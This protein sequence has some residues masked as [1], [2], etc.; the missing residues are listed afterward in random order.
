MGA[1]GPF[2]R[3]D[4]VRRVRALIELYTALD[5]ILDGARRLVVRDMIKSELNEVKWLRG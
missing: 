3:R 5:C 1:S 2:Q 4:S